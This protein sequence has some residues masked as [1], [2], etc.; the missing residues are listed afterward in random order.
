MD[1]DN[2]TNFS[3]YIKNITRVTPFK[4]AIISPSYIDKYGRTLYSHITFM[5]LDQE[6]DLLCYQFEK[7][8]IKKGMLTILM[9]KPSIEFFL[10]L[11]ALFKIG[12]IPIIPYATKNIKG[13][14]QYLKGVNASAFIGTPFYQLL[15]F[16]HPIA[17]KNIETSITIKPGKI[18]KKSSSSNYS[19]ANK[20]Y[21]ANEANKDDVIAIFLTPGITEPIKGVEYTHGMLG[22]N[23]HILK[24]LYGIT[25]EETALTPF[26]LMSLLNIAIGITA[27][28]PKMD[29][30]NISKTN[31]ET[32]IDLLKD[33]GITILQTYPAFF[34]KLSSYCKLKGIRLSSLKRADS[35]GADVYPTDLKEFSKFM[36]K[37]AGLSSIYGSIEAMVINAAECDD[38]FYETI[39]NTQKGFG[40]CIGLPINGVDVRLIK[41]TDGPIGIL[42]EHLLMSRG[43]IGEIIVKGPNVSKS[44]FKNPEYD[45]I[46][47]AQD[48]NDI[49]YRTGDIAWMDKS[50]RLWYCG[51]KNERV[52]TQEGT[53]YTI[54][55]EAIFN[56]HPYVKKTALVGVGPT[57]KQTPVICVE[58]EKIENEHAKVEK[59]LKEIAKT[60]IITE[61]IKL[62]IFLKS[63]PVDKYNGTKILRDKLKAI[64]EKMI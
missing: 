24:S 44:Y 58:L 64:V 52:V 26:I 47:R 39:K 13:I 36:Q 14:I 46:H 1:N 63:I 34:D 31:P 18:W 23:A 50:G 29:M 5:Q 11:F 62:F 51:R 35:I 20:S 37:K 17:F 55:C 33:A 61:N 16:V 57:H 19:F 7:A 3:S 60:T 32:I 30:F 38:S 25:Y 4:R 54:P 56:N 53:L 21:P 8:G 41:I 15:R 2:N 9:A 22:F 49:W 48:G 12:A 6:S 43:E 27:V 45:T 10:S 42:T 28:I 59:E 40:I